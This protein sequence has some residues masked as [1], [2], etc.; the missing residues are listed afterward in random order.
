MRGDAAMRNATVAGSAKPR[1]W[2]SNLGAAQL[3]RRSVD[4]AE[5][6]RPL[7]EVAVDDVVAAAPWRTFRWYGG[8]QHYS[9]TYWA[10][11]ESDHVIY[12]SRL[13]LARLLLADFDVGV[14]RIA[15]Q[16]FLLRCPVDG[17]ERRHI[18]DYLLLTNAG[19]VIVDVK[20][21]RRL[22]SKTVAFTFEWARSVL[23]ERGWRY[24][25]SSEPPP[26]ELENVRFLAG[27]RR[28]WLFDPDVLDAVRSVVREAITLGEALSAVA[29]YP[30]PSV[31]AALFHLLWRQEFR[32][33]LAQRLTAAS[34]LR[35]AS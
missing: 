28:A 24:E 22:E 17:K 6:I 1:D 7:D 31:R 30:E 10:A 16:P 18:P 25:M 27:Y 13:E 19:P 2:S 12:E 32:V 34:V 8:Q 23:T 3:S 29:S 35:I 21:R 20:P 14:Q 4:G 5:E 15:A 9:G 11:T 26:I 33:D